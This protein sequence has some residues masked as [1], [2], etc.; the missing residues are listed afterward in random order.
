MTFISISIF[1]IPMSF[2]KKLF[3]DSQ[4]DVWAEVAKRT[5][6]ELKSG[7]MLEAD[8]VEVNYLGSK[9]TAFLS[10]KGK[11]GTAVYTIVN[12]EFVTFNDLYNHAGLIHDLQTQKINISELTEDFP[13][14]YG[15]EYKER[16][17]EKDADLLSLRIQLIKKAITLSR[18]L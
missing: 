3:G 14:R 4:R 5:G 11:G 18:E 2:I 10:T 7:G 13:K 12:T 17:V 15:L 8:K 9:I 6:G 1:G 16:G